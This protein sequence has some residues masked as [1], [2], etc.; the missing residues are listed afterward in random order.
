MTDKTCDFLVIGAGVIGLAI[1]REILINNK[2]SKV[3]VVEKETEVGLHA[4]G[5]N[6]GV[7]HAGFYYSPD[8][9]KA[10]LT[11]DGNRLLREFCAENDVPIK[12]VGKVV[13][14]KNAQEEESLKELYRRGIENGVE[15]EI[16]DISDFKNSILVNEKIILDKGADNQLFM[17]LKI[18]SFYYSIC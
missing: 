18:D 11:V 8:S 14:T 15:I 2:N 1:A 4:S 16:V 17:F 6:S 13:V 10:K 7:L 5:R 3:I 12:N 9:L